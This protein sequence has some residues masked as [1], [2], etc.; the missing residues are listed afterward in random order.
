MVAPHS[1]C[2]CSID[3][4]IRLLFTFHKRLMKFEYF[5]KIRY[6]GL[7]CFQTG[8]IIVHL[9]IIVLHCMYNTE[10]VHVKIYV[11]FLFNYV[12]LRPLGCNLLPVETD[13]HGMIPSSLTSLL[14]HWPRGE[15]QKDDCTAPRVLYTIPNGVN[16]TGATMTLERKQEIYE[17]RIKH[18]YGNLPICNES[19]PVDTCHCNT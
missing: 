8:A 5:W 2:A 13:H 17:V 12:K 15:A 9:L 11:Y 18:L 3:M 16:P 10:T 19:C 7:H 4:N 14:S 6:L 1:Y